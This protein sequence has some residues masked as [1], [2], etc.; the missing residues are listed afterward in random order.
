MIMSYQYR[1][2][3]QWPPAQNSTLPPSRMERSS[4]QRTAIRNVID[5]AGR[6]L[7]PHE[8]CD[9]AQAEVPGLGIATVYRN[10]KQLVDAQE[11]TAVVLPGESPRF[12]S[13]QHG[14]HHHFQ[15]NEC[16]RVFDVH[17]CPGNLDSLAPEGFQ[18]EHHELTLYGRC[19][20]CVRTR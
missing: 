8:I 10:L 7:S 19:D 1:N 9:A 6:P 12:E 3:G 11:I 2:M 18:V 16:K 20:E 15:C 4:R 17:E 14:H 5:A 13:M